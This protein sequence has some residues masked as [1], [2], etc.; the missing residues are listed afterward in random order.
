MMDSVVFYFS[1]HWRGE[2]PL[3]K[4][5]WV[6]GFFGWLAITYISREISYTGNVWVAFA[7][8]ALVMLILWKGVWVSA[9]KS[10]E[11]GQK[12]AGNAA[13][14]F[15]SLAVFWYIMSTVRN[16]FGF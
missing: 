16:Q 5:F 11:N 3:W 7:T 2:L 1:R 8:W 10:K 12:L 15:I 9:S 4:A 13:Q 14:A 6:N